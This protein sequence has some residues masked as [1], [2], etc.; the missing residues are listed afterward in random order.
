[1]V[2]GKPFHVNVT[3]HVSVWVE[4]NT[5]IVKDKLEKSRSTWA[6]ELKCIFVIVGSQ[7]IPSR[8][9]WACELKFEMKDTEEEEAEVTLHVSV[10]VEIC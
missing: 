9:T 1:M 4:M 5:Q 2:S 3:L 7:F 6:C 8:S 10:W